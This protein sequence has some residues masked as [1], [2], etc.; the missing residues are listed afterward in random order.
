MS[1]VVRE[2]PEHAPLVAEFLR[3][4][5]D[6]TATPEKVL[7]ARADAAATNPVNPGE[8]PPTFLFLHDGRVAGFVTTIPVKLW[9][10]NTERGV[11]WLKG[12]MVLPEL[13]NGP[14]GFLTLKE[15]VRELPCA[16]S[17]VVAPPARRLFEALGFTPVGLL[18]NAVRI[19]RPSTFVR[20]LDLDAL[21]V[22]S[23]PRWAPAA[24]NAARGAGLT[25]LISG[26][27]W[28]GGETLGG[29]RRFGNIGGL[30][31]SDRADIPHADTTAL[32]HKVR[33]ELMCSP[34]RDGETLSRH[35]A[36]SADAAAYRFVEV[37]DGKRLRALAVVRRPSEH[38]DARLK[39]IRVATLSDLL[40]APSDRPALLAALRGAESAARLAG[41]DA[42]LCSASHPAYASAA[43]QT[44]FVPAGANV[45]FMVRHADRKASVPPFGS[46]HLMRGDSRADE[47]F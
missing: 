6:A 2:R 42:L 7:D 37:R 35:Y 43:V 23:L 31:I 32:W 44:G 46:W 1:E 16:L 39:G 22:G 13:R 38:G 11:H 12:L 47:V 26:A 24:F 20:K 45:H 8:Q 30:S 41:G 19:V 5:W 27:L 25:P 4:V 17:M 9:E 33:D 10:A 29:L 34:V 28:A 21:G 40:C 3:S 36:T 15:A 14:V 18:P